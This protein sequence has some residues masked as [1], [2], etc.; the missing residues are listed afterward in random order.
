MLKLLTKYKMWFV[1]VLGL[2]RLCI[3]SRFTKVKRCFVDFY[4]DCLTEKD[5]KY[6]ELKDF[7][8]SLFVIK[9]RNNL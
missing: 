4:N 7:M 3:L 1:V 9:K 5:K 2:H 8:S 6:P